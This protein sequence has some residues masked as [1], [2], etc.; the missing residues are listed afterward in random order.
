MVTNEV[1]GLKATVYSLGPRGVR[2]TEKAGK[3]KRDRGISPEGEMG[4]RV[5]SLRSGY[6]ATWILHTCAL[7]TLV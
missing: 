5:G 4:F 7:R 3:S 2:V 1:M 6:Q